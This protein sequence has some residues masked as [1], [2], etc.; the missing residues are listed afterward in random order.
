MSTTY[1]WPGETVRIRVHFVGED[2]QPTT[3]TGVAMSY[4]APGA[5]APT[6]IAPGSITE[7]DT[8][9]YYTDLPLLT[10]GDWA[11]RATCSTPTA[12]A[13]EV[14]FCVLQSTVL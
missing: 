4:R 7:D 6:S 1:F 13:V 3:V 9:A 2:G 12:S 14:G 10:P 8:G 11:V 5:T